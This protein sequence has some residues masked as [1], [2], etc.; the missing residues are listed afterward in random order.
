MP[1]CSAATASKSVCAVGSGSAP[2]YASRSASAVQRTGAERPTP[3]GSKPTRSNRR[4]TSTGMAEAS[5]TAVSTPEA[6]GPPGLTTTEP[7]RSAARWAV[8]C[9]RT[10]EM[11]NVLPSLGTAPVAVAQSWGTATVAQENST[12]AGT[13]SRIS[14]ASSGQER[15]RA[16]GTSPPLL[17]GAA[18]V[19]PLPEVGETQRVA[20]VT[21]PPRRAVVSRTATTGRRRITKL[22]PASVPARRP[23][24]RRR[25]TATGA[26]AERTCTSRALDLAATA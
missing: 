12:L 4:V 21:H 5:C 3:L 10:S 2:K 11:S 22:P 20:G 18:D 24:R 19:A 17:L 14:L 26:Q 7:I 23:G 6:P 9:T 25:R 13:R 8:E 15:H 16:S 1:R